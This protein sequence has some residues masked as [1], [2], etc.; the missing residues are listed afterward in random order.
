MITVT[1]EQVD[2]IKSKMTIVVNVLIA[3][4]GIYKIIFIKAESSNYHAYIHDVIMRIN[5]F[6]ERINI[7]NIEYEI[8]M[9]KKYF[10]LKLN[11][12]D[13]IELIK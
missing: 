2:N 13:L 11:N 4:I 7:D 6:I 5:E 9:L 1:Q 12:T 8:D 3:T 10:E